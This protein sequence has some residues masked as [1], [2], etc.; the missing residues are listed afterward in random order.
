[1]GTTNANTP[2]VSP[3]GV[4]LTYIRPLLKMRLLQMRKNILP[5]SVSASAP[6][7]SLRRVSHLDGGIPFL[8]RS[9]LW[10]AARATS[11]SWACSQSTICIS[12]SFTTRTHAS[13]LRCSCSSKSPSLASASPLL[14]APMITP[15]SR[16]WTFCWLWLMGTQLSESTAPLLVPFWYSSSN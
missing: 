10:H 15:S 8:R 9:H 1:M 6:R 14:D 11:T 7:H 12:S 3:F 2:S 13:W 5:C 16:D 4:V